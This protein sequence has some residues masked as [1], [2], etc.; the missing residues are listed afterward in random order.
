MER[1]ELAGNLLGQELARLLEDPLFSDITFLLA[2]GSA[3][4]T[5]RAILAARSSYFATVFGAPGGASFR[6]AGRDKLEVPHLPPA[7]FRLVL[8]YCYTGDAPI[9]TDNVLPLLE[10]AAYYLLPGLQACCTHFLLPVLDLGGAQQAPGSTASTASSGSPS[11]GLPSGQQHSPQRGEPA[12]EA[13]AQPAHAQRSG[14]GQR[15]KDGAQ[16]Q[17]AVRSLAEL[18][19][20]AAEQGVGAVEAATA[21]FACARFAFASR[22]PGFWQLVPDRMLHLLAD[23]GSDITAPSERCVLEGVVGWCWGQL[24]AARAALSEQRQEEQAAVHEGQA[25]RGGAA[26]QAGAGRAASLCCSQFSPMAVRPIGAVA[27]GACSVGSDADDAAGPSS[28]QQQQ[29]W[30]PCREALAAAAALPDD[31]ALA[32]V[33][34]SEAWWG[35]SPLRCGEGE[36]WT[37]VVAAVEAV[38][39]ALWGYVRWGMLPSPPSPLLCPLARALA[40][41]QQRKQREEAAWSRSGGVWGDSPAGHGP[42]ATRH[43]TELTLDGVLPP[44]GPTAARPTTA[45]GQVMP[46]GAPPAPAVN[47]DWLR[48]CCGSLRRLDL[49]GCASLTPQAARTIAQCSLL[50]WLSLSGCTQLT[51]AALVAALRGCPRLSWLSLERCSALG[52]GLAGALDGLCSLRYLSL[53][54]CTGLTDAAFSRVGQLTWGWG[55]CDAVDTVSLAGCTHITHAGI[56]RLAQGCANLR[57]LHVGGTAA[58]QEELRHL[59]YR[60]GYARL[61]FVWD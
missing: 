16:R 53:A 14:E 47:L 29:Q 22:Q 26:R 33:L 11:L 15:Q 40:E 31:P 10:A 37:A 55:W 8:Q 12:A 18:W 35:T 54:G 60:P 39:A 34:R 32:A 3:V 42:R 48:V 57:C 24:R 50:E 4:Q 21:D 45:A 58:D 13:A 49:S 7:T 52:D 46:R 56:E 30:G 6:E 17:W 20:T 1:T 23:R 44:C 61:T 2:D 25:A 43:S 36:A 27:S 9:S 28:S 19:N 59:E 38:G 5:H 51:D 41:R